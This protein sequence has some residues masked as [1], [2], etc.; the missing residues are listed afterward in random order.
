MTLEGIL[1]FVIQRVSIRTSNMMETDLG[2]HPYASIHYIPHGYIS[3]VVDVIRSFWHIVVSWNSIKGNCRNCNLSD[4]VILVNPKEVV[5]VSS[6]AGGA[7][8]SSLSTP[9]PEI[10]CYT[11]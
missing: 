10:I 2:G 8:N 1:E 3:F 6:R 9:K 7:G 4:L 11:I 5:H